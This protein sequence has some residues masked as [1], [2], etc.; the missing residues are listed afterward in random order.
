MKL[1]TY[2][3]TLTICHRRRHRIASMPIGTVKYFNGKEGF[4]F[5]APDGGGKQ[6]YVDLAAVV[7]AGMSSLN[8]KQRVRYDIQTDEKGKRAAVNLTRVGGKRGGAA[9]TNGE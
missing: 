1:R 6:D 9:P 5:I 4:G 2:R 8:Q 3:T 7:Q